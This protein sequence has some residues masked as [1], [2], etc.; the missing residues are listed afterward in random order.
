MLWDNADK[1]QTGF[2]NGFGDGSNHIY[3][4]NN[5]SSQEDKL[6]KILQIGL[7]CL[8]N[9]LPDEKNGGQSEYPEMV[10]LLHVRNPRAT[11]FAE[12][13]CSMFWDRVVGS[14]FRR[15]TY[16]VMN[17]M[18]LA[19][20]KREPDFGWPDWSISVIMARISPAIIRKS[21]L[22]ADFPGRVL[23]WNKADLTNDY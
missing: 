23:D 21:G 1:T 6:P 10:G 7:E 13:D 5:D 2:S 22:M 16:L 15:G 12:F 4:A 18:G 19:L 11:A 14:N 17:C 8:Y 3:I 20:E 9:P